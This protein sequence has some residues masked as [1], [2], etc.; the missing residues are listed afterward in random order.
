MSLKTFGWNLHGNDE[1][2]GGGKRRLSVNWVM[3]ITSG[4]PVIEGKEVISE[5]GS[6]LWPWEMVITGWK[7]VIG[8]ALSVVESSTNSLSNHLSLQD[9]IKQEI[10]EKCG[11]C[12]HPFSL[13]LEHMEAPHGNISLPHLFAPLT[14]LPNGVSQD[15][16][17]LSRNFIVQND[18]HPDACAP[19]FFIVHEDNTVTFTPVGVSHAGDIITISY[20]AVSHGSPYNELPTFTVVMKKIVKSST[21]KMEACLQVAE[22]ADTGTRAWLADSMLAPLPMLAHVLADP[23]A[24][25]E[26]WHSS[27]KPHQ[28]LNRALGPGYLRTEIRDG[29]P[30]H[31]WFW[32]RV[33]ECSH[34]VID[35]ETW[36]ANEG[37]LKTLKGSMGTLSPDE[38]LI[39]NSLFG[40]IN[41]DS[42]TSEFLIS[43]G[44]TLA[45]VNGRRVLMTAWLA[46]VACCFSTAEP[47]LSFSEW[48]QC[49]AQH[50]ADNSIAEL[51]ANWWLYHLKAQ[52]MKTIVEVWILG[53]GLDKSEKDLSDN[54]H[55][56]LAKLLEI[57]PP[58][59]QS[60]YLITA[61]QALH[62]SL[63]LPDM[64]RVVSLGEE[65]DLA[66]AIDTGNSSY[67]DKDFRG[68]AI[69]IA[70]GKGGMLPKLG[71]AWLTDT[72]VKVKGEKDR[73]KGPD[74]NLKRFHDT[75]GAT[76][77][78]GRKVVAFPYSGEPLSGAVDVTDGVDCL[79]FSRPAPQDAKKD[80]SLWTPPPLAYGFRYWAAG[81]A[82]GNGGLIVDPVYQS[83]DGPYS[84]LPA[85]LVTYSGDGMLYLCRVSPGAVSVQPVSHQQTPY[86]M[87]NQSRGWSQQPASGKRA[88]V[89]VICPGTKGW[90]S[91]APTE[92]K[93]TLTA[94]DATKL[95]LTRWIEADICNALYADDEKLAQ[96]LRE[97]RT[98]LLTQFDAAQKGKSRDVPRHPAVKAIGLEVI[99]ERTTPSKL[100]IVKPGYDI[101]SG[102]LA[103][104]ELKF[105]TGSKASAELKDGNVVLTLPPGTIAT[106]NI[107]SLVPETFFSSDTETRMADFTGGSSSW[108][109]YRAFAYNQHLFECLPAANSMVEDTT[110][111][112]T[113]VQ[114]SLKITTLDSETTT[115]LADEK[116]FDA[117]WLAGFLVQ[118][119]E[120]HW[121]GYPLA[122]PKKLLNNQQL[123]QWSEAFAGTSSLRETQNHPLQT[124][125]PTSLTD[126]RFALPA[127]PAVLCRLRLPR[128]HGARFF[129]CVMR[130]IL[131][132]HQ[133]LDPDSIKTLENIIIAKGTVVAA[134]VN[135]N[136]PSL[137]LAPPTIQTAIPLVR[138]VSVQG[139]G[140]RTGTNG[141]LICLDEALCRTDSLTQ[142]SGVGETFE[143]DLEAT[144]YAGISEIGPN[145]I[146]HA[147]PKGVELPDS[148]WFCELPDATWFSK[149]GIALRKRKMNWSIEA[150]R[151]F[152]LTNDTDSNPKVAQTAIIVRPTGNDA[153]AY[154]IMAK[155]RI[156]RMLDP[157]KNWTE[158]V[159][160]PSTDESWQLGRRAE[161]D[162]FV[163]YDFALEIP[164][165]SA[166]NLALKGGEGF[167]VPA[168]GEKD[169]LRRLLCS[170]HKGQWQDKAEFSWSLQIVD[171]I[172]PSS[173]EQ[174]ITVA[175]YSPWQTKAATTDLPIKSALPVEIKKTANCT[176]RRLLL[177][178]YGESHWLTF[179]GMPY[180]HP[181]IADEQFNMA[182]DNGVITLKRSSVVTESEIISRDLLIE[183]IDPAILNAE[184]NEEDGDEKPQGGTFHLLLVFSP[185]NDVAAPAPSQQLGQLTGIYYPRRAS[186]TDQNPYPELS[187]HSYM[188]SSAM[189]EGS[190]GYI[191]KFQ[192]TDGVPEN[193]TML[194]SWMFPEDGTEAKVRWLP[195]FIGPITTNTLSVHNDGM[196]EGVSVRLLKDIT[197]KI[198]TD[199]GW[200]FATS[201]RLQG[202]SDLTGG[203]CTFM[204]NDEL[205]LIGSG[206]RLIATLASWSASAGKMT[207]YDKDG[208]AIPGDGS[209]QKQ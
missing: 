17:G 147:G 135:W 171:Q 100:L 156:R 144:R 11:D 123:E 143:V 126:W 108:P 37:V 1:G 102:F 25:Q 18:T 65:R 53:K 136:N 165:S 88:R 38:N 201:K 157:H 99:F 85:E 175:R 209:W 155:V 168:T 130:P 137:R 70:M 73:I 92:A 46:A 22:R 104:C 117:T 82:M 74:G 105:M 205:A 32:D 21:V 151:P 162:D 114:Q 95:V 158:S 176:A 183:P 59:E 14:Q 29:E 149:A 4:D 119:H 140:I 52:E 129:A 57:V 187:F 138:T 8:D 111:L 184:K 127:A 86:L 206:G 71:S 58:T 203:L 24:K 60:P 197:I 49:L 45:N 63:T 185:V 28:L 26:E 166:F 54:Y 55:H 110:T 83:P 208:N 131:R 6:L 173:G 5:A 27:I 76:V 170:W 180:R 200:V 196:K 107:W 9:K 75:V 145:P 190:V 153:H 154:W 141:S 69:A 128:Y 202:A 188:N 23:T 109:G 118:R 43:A 36:D 161:G 150:D 122:L 87:E 167:T 146:F 181:A 42:V 148:S 68:Y 40:S 172:I 124:N 112:L 50:Y 13:A 182:I 139:E 152:G 20:A 204:D 192:F 79:D 30:K 2:G 106:V 207:S 78:N 94:P 7:L 163:P 90:R 116:G 93:F 133:W 97:N 191:Y 134:R 120:W 125:Q 80:A 194:Q 48:Y 51:Q 47:K 19:E 31:I 16:L 189:P 96:S 142:F 41:S 159:E 10:S 101:K 33:P 186:I 121:T 195:E 178:D 199:R 39:L 177:S 164:E 98:Q 15:I 67:E 64:Q 44:M 160:L 56:M 132:F 89:A 12:S 179:I 193:W 174:W 66:I 62:Q 81:T 84:L 3:P 91:S 61:S 34:I 113:A 72:T 77:Q 35:I 115:Q 198:D 103:S 169:S